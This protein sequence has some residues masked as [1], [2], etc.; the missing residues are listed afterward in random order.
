MYDRADNSGTYVSAVN[1]ERSHGSVWG[2][3]D[4]LATIGSLMHPL[5]FILLV[6]STYLRR[7]VVDDLGMAAGGIACHEVSLS[8]VDFRR[9]A[10]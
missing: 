1:R 3:L 4:E 7:G 10:L 9:I 8:E 5:S 6:M 2:N